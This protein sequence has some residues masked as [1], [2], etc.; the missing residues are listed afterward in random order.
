VVETP[1]G[2]RHRWLIASPNGPTSEGI[3][4]LCGARRAFRNSADDFISDGTAPPGLA[5]S[6][7]I[8]AS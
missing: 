3:C 8:T 6:I 5:A 7:E 1:A 2:C 4:R